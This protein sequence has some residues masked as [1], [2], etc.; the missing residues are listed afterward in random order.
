MPSVRRLIV[1]NVLRNMPVALVVVD[2]KGVIIVASPSAHAILGASPRQLAGRPW[3]ELVLDYPENGAFNQLVTE[4]VEQGRGFSHQE[5]VRRNAKGRLTRLSL[6]AAVLEQGE[7]NA[8]VVI[9]MDDVTAL[10]EAQERETSIL[11]EKN[12]LQYDMIESMNTL[13]LSVAHQIRNRTAAIGGFSLKLLRDLRARDMS[14]AYPEIIFQEA[15]RLEDV[16]GAVVR[17]ASISKLRPELANIKTVIEKAVA[18]AGKIAKGLRKNISWTL[19][20][21]EREFMADPDLLRMAL[22]EILLNAIE[23][24]NAAEVSVTI[25]ARQGE[26]YVISVTDDGPGVAEGSRPFVFDPFY[27]TKPQGFGVGLTIARKIIIEHDGRLNLEH[28]GSGG[29]EAVIRLG[30]ASRER[31]F[32]PPCD[33]RLFDVE[34]LSRKA[35]Q[36]GA[37]ISGMNY[38][39][40][41]RAVQAREGYSPCFGHG[42]FDRC[43]QKGCGFRADCM[44]IKIIGASKDPVRRY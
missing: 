24:S 33:G 41:V 31:L 16:V 30:G 18:E 21:E 3:T 10:R 15:K 22:M 38:I 1:D 20:L 32:T 12:S 26:E 13:A 28:N 6:T 5:A 11:R 34:T 23:F 43:G 25:T 8:G 40:A 19:D 42:L 36:A 39:D 17:L 7:K 29:T 2:H 35:A 9:L 44:Q 37:D 27:S 14:T 4:A